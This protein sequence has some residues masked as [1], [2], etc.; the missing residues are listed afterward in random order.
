MTEELLADYFTAFV[1][2]VTCHHSNAQRTSPQNDIH[3]PVRQ[4]SKI[5]CHEVI[6]MGVDKS[7]ALI[8]YFDDH[9]ASSVSF[10]P[11]RTASVVLAWLAAE[12]TQSAG[13]PGK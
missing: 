9:V 10:V 11:D 3:F 5:L 1:G 12:S 4:L 13:S 6:C 2:R 7:H 8:P